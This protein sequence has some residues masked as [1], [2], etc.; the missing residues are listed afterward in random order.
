MGIQNEAFKVRFY[1]VE[2]NAWRRLVRARHGRTIVIETM[3]PILKDLA[4]SEVVRDAKNENEFE[5][6]AR[7]RSQTSQVRQ[8]PKN[9]NAS[10][11]P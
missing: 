2:Y 9:Q 11:R 6:G 1:D 4:N 7:K 8:N 5:E 10:R 3:F